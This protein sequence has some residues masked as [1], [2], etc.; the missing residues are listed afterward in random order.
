LPVIIHTRNAKDDTLKYIKESG[1]KKFVI[2]C[3][4]ENYEFAK[5]IM[6][7]SREAYF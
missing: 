7:Y 4:T 1:I 6:D 5:E 2:H 3:F